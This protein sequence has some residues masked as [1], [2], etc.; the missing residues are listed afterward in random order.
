MASL[1]PGILL[2]LLQHLDDKQTKVAG[3]HRSAL[4]QVISIVP[5]LGDDPWKS[6]GF[7]LRVSDSQHSAYVSVSEEDVDLILSDK[8]QLGQF[9]HV[10]RLDSGSPVPVLRGVKPVPKRRPCVGDPK[11]LISSDFL[12]ARNRPDPKR[13]KKNA[14]V[15]RVEVKTKVNR[16]VVSEDRD[17]K[18]RRQSVGNG[19][20]E[21]LEMRRLS[22]D[23]V[24][25][26]WD[27][28]P[29]EKNGAGATPR[30]K[31]KSGFSGSDSL[32][33]VKK[34]SFD[35]VSTPRHSTASISPLTNKNIIVSPRSVTKPTRKDLDL[36]QD[37]TLPCNLTKVALSFKNWSDSRI[38]WSSLPSTVRDL[39]KEVTSYRNV[40]FLSAMH[41][42]EESAAAEGVI[43]CMSMFAELCES[44]KKVPAG[45]LV[46]QYLNLHE[47]MQKAAAVVKS[48]VTRRTPEAKGSDKFCLPNPFPEIC[49]NFTNKNAAS[50]IQAA[51]DS[52]LSSFC[53]FI[54][55][56]KKGNLDNEKSHYIIL[57]NNPKNSEAENQ[58][59][60]NKQSP[61]TNGP[62][63]HDSSGRRSVSHSKQH[64]PA[65]R[66]TKT[67]R[68][69]WSKGSGLKESAILSEKLLASSRAWF[70]NFLEDSLNKGFGLNTVEG[71]SEIPGLLGQLKRV[72]QWLDDMVK[73]GSRVDERVEGLRKKLY[74]F[75]LDHIDSSILGG[76]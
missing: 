41:A 15:K 24:R 44:S 40:V 54:K 46:E 37:E 43:Q 29:G 9:I 72:N 48:L 16:V 66:R 35:K 14:E 75:L 39:G 3:E 70:L 19:K 69:Q 68:E 33:S 10:N 31:S 32:P 38:S 2:K 56:G 11:D 61:K 65:I 45:Q 22:L 18:S 20:V 12:T 26:G 30:S 27:R 49:H 64:L 42:L 74:R 63:G 47:N 13:G 51:I 76:K 34:P 60:K 23:S 1:T 58:S 59:P 6:R 57:E 25:K 55:E 17:I 5:S 71:N 36:L 28:S 8:I 7:Y 67:E 73:L 62:S 52:E 53:L 4:L 50:W 21:G